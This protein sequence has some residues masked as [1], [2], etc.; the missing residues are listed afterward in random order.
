ME[1]LSSCCKA[2]IIINKFDNNKIPKNSKKWYRCSKCG[3]PIGSPISMTNYNKLKEK[4]EE[5]FDEMLE[6]IS[7]NIPDEKSL[8]DFLDYYDDD[9]R[10][11][12]NF[13][14]KV[15][16]ETI[17]YE[18]KKIKKEFIKW[19]NSKETAEDIEDAIN[20]ILK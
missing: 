20:R 3:R 4:Q 12:K 5:E 2:K 17:E 13:I 1:Q 16:Q 15:R 6:N 10:M 8:N 11:L 19:F 7:D 14:Y 9:I 18:R